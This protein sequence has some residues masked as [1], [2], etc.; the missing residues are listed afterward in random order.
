MTRA[1]MLDQ[2]I[3]REGPYNH[4]TADRGGATCFGITQ[5][6][7]SAWLG[8][9]ATLTELKALTPEHAKAIY[10]ALYYER[11]RIA[12]LPEPLDDLMFDFAVN[13]GPFI[14]IR[15]LQETLG[16]PADMVIGPV[17]LAACHTSDLQPIINGVIRWRCMM[18]ARIC[19]RDP[20]QLTFL[21]GW[22]KRAFEFLA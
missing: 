20:S 8:R 12:M 15:A 17:T 3:R 2:V 22:L 5:T 10:E 9:P 11:P 4:L 18:L 16:L 1:D 19:R 7:L 13:S 21:Q 6:T 14:A